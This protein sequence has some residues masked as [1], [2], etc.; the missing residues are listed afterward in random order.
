MFLF[1]LFP[2]FHFKIRFGKMIQIIEGVVVEDVGKYLQ[3]GRK[4]AAILGPT[5]ERAFWF[6]EKRCDENIK[7]CVQDLVRERRSRTYCVVAFSAAETSATPSEADSK[8]VVKGRG[9]GRRRMSN[10]QGV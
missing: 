9:R 2:H 10:S 4:L 1:I 7:R 6:R 8:Q 3:E 5:F